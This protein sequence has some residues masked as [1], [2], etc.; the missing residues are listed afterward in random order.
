MQECNN[1]EF[2]GLWVIRNCLG[3]FSQWRQK[4][5]WLNLRSANPPKKT[6]GAC[7]KDVQINNAVPSVY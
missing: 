7:G 5:L 3:A 1:E 4:L 2:Y 6:C